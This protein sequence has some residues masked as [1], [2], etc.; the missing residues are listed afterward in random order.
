MPHGRADGGSAM[1]PNLSNMA[2]R[3]LDGC[4]TPDELGR[5]YVISG[6]VLPADL[7][8]SMDAYS[9]TTVLLE[10]SPEKWTILYANDAFRTATGISP[11]VFSGKQPT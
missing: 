10:V 2:A 1:L 11:K 4:A 5:E 9:W 7:R 3:E 6:L 8:E